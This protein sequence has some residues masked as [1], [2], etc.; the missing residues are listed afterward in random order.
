MINVKETSKDFTPVEQYLM[1]ASP[2]IMT[3]K[4]VEDN[5][6][7]EVAGYMLFE[8]VKED[9]E[10]VTELL[11]IITPDNRAYCCQSKTFKRSFLD[12]AK[13]MGDTPFSIIKIS[14]QT[15]AGRDFINCILDVDSLA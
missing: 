11:S 8:D 1:T 12:I 4:D 15:K 7:I 6:K 14:G 5:T 10:G 2:G 3:V 13:I 9:F